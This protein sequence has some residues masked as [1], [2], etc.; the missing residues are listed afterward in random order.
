MIIFWQVEEFV[1]MGGFTAERGKTERFQ[2]FFQI[3][4]M[5]LCTGKII[6]GKM[7][8][9]IGTVRSLA[10]IVFKCRIQDQKISGNKVVRIT[11]RIIFF[12]QKHFAIQNKIQDIFIRSAA[13]MY[14]RRG[15]SDMTGKGDLWKLGTSYFIIKRIHGSVPPKIKY[16]SNHSFS[17]NEN[18]QKIN[19]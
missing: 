8:I 15:N 3:R 9:I 12:F 19:R 5:F 14:I 18:I 2:G 16:K 17:I 7:N 13:G 6:A 1:F 4:E 11:F 10:A